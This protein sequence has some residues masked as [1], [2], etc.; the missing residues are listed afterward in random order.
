MNRRYFALVLSVG[1][2]VSAGVVEGD[3]QTLMTRHVREAT[4]NGQAKVLGRLPATQIMQLNIVLP[5]RDQAGL[6]ALLAELYNP[7]S[8]D[9][10][11]FLTPAEFTERFGP[12][13]QDYD[14]VVQYV[15]AYG[16]TVVGGS[17]DGMD[18]QVKAPVSAIESAFQVK[19]QT[20]RHPSENRVFYGP[21][22][23]PTVGLPFQLWHVSWGW[24]DFSAFRIR[25]MSRKA[26]MRERM[27]LIRMQSSGTPL[28][29]PARRLRFWVAICAR[30]I[31]AGQP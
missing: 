10:R 21:D 5:L 16:L 11:H 27:G 28:P 31:M 30:P 23:E 22:R 26:T 9:Y 24:T 13:Q 17:R 19:M 3:A 2:F 1:V 14:S 25:C 15:R 18:V 4:L 7:N 6:D 29:G 20:Y 12:S 8:P